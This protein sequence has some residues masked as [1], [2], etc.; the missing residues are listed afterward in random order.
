MPENATVELWM[1]NAAP[2]GRRLQS[3]KVED[4]TPVMISDVILLIL[5]VASL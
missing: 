1:M 5:T 3:K 4:G 2:T